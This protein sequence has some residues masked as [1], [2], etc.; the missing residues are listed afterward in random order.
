MNDA[1]ILAIIAIVLSALNLLSIY[2]EHK[3]R[4]DDED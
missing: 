3:K 2:I 4:H 1:L